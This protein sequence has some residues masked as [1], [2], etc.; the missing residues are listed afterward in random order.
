MSRQRTSTT[1]RIHAVLWPLIILRRS[2][3]GDEASIR[4]QTIV[5]RH[6]DRG[7]S[8]R[9]SPRGIGRFEFARCLDRDVRPRQLRYAG[10]YRPIDHRDGHTLT[11]VPL[12][13]RLIQLVIRE[14]VLSRDRV[15]SPSRRRRHSHS[16]H[17]QRKSTG[18]SN[19][20]ARGA[21]RHTHKHAGAVGRV[22]R[23]RHEVTSGDRQGSYQYERRQFR[24]QLRPHPPRDTHNYHR[25][26]HR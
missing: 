22:R 9:V 5:L 6:Q 4:S 15:I 13:T 10:I 3:V 24:R 21:P 11:R 17:T 25:T 14:V 18:S 23:R 8:G 16:T 2:C 12:R 26:P 19:Q 7:D 20:S 1:P